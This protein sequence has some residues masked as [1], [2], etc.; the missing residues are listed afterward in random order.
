M[1]LIKLKVSNATKESLFKYVE[2]FRGK[3]LD[4]GKEIIL[5]N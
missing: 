4:V 5:L 1:A 3:I 2:I